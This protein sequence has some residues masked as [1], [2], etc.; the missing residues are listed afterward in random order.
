MTE[1]LESRAHSAGGFGGEGILLRLWS[2]WRARKEVARL[3][4][5]DDHILKDIGLRREDISWAANQPLNVNAA[6]ALE[7]QG[8][9]ARFK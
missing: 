2:N 5:L 3:N 1:Y 9:E 8:L 7:D 6:L 4:R